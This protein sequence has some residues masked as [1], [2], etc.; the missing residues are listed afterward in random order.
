MLYLSLPGRY[1]EKYHA[2]QTGAKCPV[3][4]LEQRVTEIL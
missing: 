1:N 3:N 4:I 2:R